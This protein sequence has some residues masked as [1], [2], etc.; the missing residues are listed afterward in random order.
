MLILTYNKAL[1]STTILC[2]NRLVTFAFIRHRV[3]PSLA[4]IL[5]DVTCAGNKTVITLL[6]NR[7]VIVLYQL[8]WQMSLTSHCSG[9][10]CNF[11]LICSCSNETSTLHYFAPSLVLHV[12][13]LT[14]TTFI[15]FTYTNGVFHMFLR[16]SGI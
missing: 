11:S 7:C 8:P 2:D 3:C 9:T 15:T 4:K 14:F 1:E 5:Y 13:T 6:C 16:T 10:R 12:S